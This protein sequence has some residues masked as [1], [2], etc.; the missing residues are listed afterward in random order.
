MKNQYYPQ[1]VTHP[2]ITLA[3]KL[4]E[5]LMTQREFARSIDMQASQFN[6]ILN[7]K[8]KVSTKMA[9][10][11]EPIT[12]IPAEFWVKAQALYD[13]AEARKKLTDE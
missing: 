2:G 11:L 12:K 13:L 10:K 8:R 6:E 1:S 3:E 4:G 9:L 7:G 5:L